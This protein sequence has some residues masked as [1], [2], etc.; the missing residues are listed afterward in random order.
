MTDLPI[1]WSV[2]LKA[3]EEKDVEIDD[4]CVLNIT[5]VCLGE[6]DEKDIKGPVR[7]NLHVETPD[8]SDLSSNELIKNDTI[9][10]SLIPQKVE[11]QMIQIL[12]SQLNIAK[13]HN[14]GSIPVCLSGHF[15][16]LDIFDEEEDFPEEE[17]EKR[18]NPKA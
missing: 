16:F 13:L 1:F 7:V 3:G 15:E 11:Q 9:I 8:I 6:Y 2:T 10:A 17:D 14:K 5:N 18:N 4:D 12:L